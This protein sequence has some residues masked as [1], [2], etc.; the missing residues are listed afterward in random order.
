M[1]TG[2]FAGVGGA[3]CGNASSADVG[4][5]GDTLSVLLA[6]R[7]LATRPDPLSDTVRFACVAAYDGLCF[8]GWM[9]QKGETLTVQGCLEQRLQSL[10]RRDVWVVAHGRTDAGVHSA[11][12]VFHFDITRAEATRLAGTTP[13]PDQLYVLTCDA[14]SARF[15]ARRSSCGKEYH[16][17]VGEAR[18]HPLAARGMHVLT[19]GCKA[20]DLDAM[21]KAAAA[22]LGE[23]VRDWSFLAHKSELSGDWEPERCKVRRL[24]K[25]EV[26]R[27]GAVVT[28]RIA[29]DFFLWNMC[30]RIAG[31]LVSVGQGRCSAE[32]VTDPARCPLVTMPA[33]GLMLQE[34]WYADDGV[35]LDPNAEGFI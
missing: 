33:K 5:Q 21:Q 22:L 1:S 13:L 17:R 4:R 6:Q 18:P 32:E 8:H 16:Y 25:L 27:E 2:T 11:G 34:V 23:G 20:L 9:K 29:G 31:L 3:G 14:V 35:G 10:L 12:T 15:H 7:A 24:F 30:R 19:G 28:I 26:V